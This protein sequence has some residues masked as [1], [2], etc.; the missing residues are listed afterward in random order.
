MIDPAKQRGGAD[1][2]A[3][4]I[5]LR[6][7]RWLGFAEYGDPHGVPLFAFHG[8]P[9]SRLMVQVADD[10]A[11][12]HGVRLIAP[13]R[14]GYGLSSR[15]AGRRFADWPDDVVA[16]ADALGIARFGVVGVS[17]GGPHA[18][19]CAWKIPERLSMV[20]TVS[21]VAP[22]AGG[23]LPSLDRQHHAAL[24]LARSVPWLIGPVVTLGRFAWRRFPEGMYRRLQALGPRAD[25]TVLARPEVAKSLIAGLCEG[26][27][28]GSRGAAEELRLFIRPWGFPLEDITVPVQI[29]HGA[30]DGL[31]PIAAAH[32]LVALIPNCRLE[33]VP[34]GGHYVIYDLIDGL[35]ET[36]RPGGLDEY[37]GREYEKASAPS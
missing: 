28:R 1:R 17:G 8:T 31:V 33:V 18:L 16:L 7:G 35:L 37:Q 11:R 4:R 27:R 13:D 29:W 9:G 36:V 25:R 32:R 26:L 2:T 6:D 14:P 12:L 19:A 24:E 20:G 15:Q 21:G 23:D 3:Q 5:V 10:A 22:I 34:D 30:H